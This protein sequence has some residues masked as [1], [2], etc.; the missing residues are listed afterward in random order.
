[1]L[2]CHTDQSCLPSSQQPKL[3]YATKAPFPRLVYLTNVPTIV[4][5]VRDW[6]I[7][8]PRIE[9][10]L[11][12][13]WCVVGA[14]HLYKYWPWSVSHLLSVS[15]TQFRVY[16][17][18]MFCIPTTGLYVASR[19]MSLVY[20]VRIIRC[21]QWPNTRLVGT[22]SQW[23]GKHLLGVLEYICLPSKRVVETA[24]LSFTWHI[25]GYKIHHHHHHHVQKRGLG[26]LPVP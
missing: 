18:D 15:V 24:L 12:D 26:V 6:V 20:T 5:L 9:V 19:N 17:F 3:T 22:R 4:H 16:H 1:M 10:S 23:P 7:F 14:V 11:L 13:T 8:I 21:V 25:V 2:K